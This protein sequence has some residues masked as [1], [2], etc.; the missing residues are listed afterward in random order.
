MLVDPVDRQQVDKAHSSPTFSYRRKIDKNGTL[1]KS[2][3]DNITF[4]SLYGTILHSCQGAVVVGWYREAGL[5][6]L[7][8]VCFSL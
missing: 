8:T 4:F 6:E 5:S 7:G 2:G 1:E 3:S